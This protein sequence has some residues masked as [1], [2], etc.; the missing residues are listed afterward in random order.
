MTQTPPPNERL[1]QAILAVIEQQIRENNPP[2]TQQTLDRLMG[3]GLTKDKALTLIG[4]VVGL[5]VL[6]VMN[7]G[8]KFDEAAYIEKLLALPAMPWDAEK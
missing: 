7:R 3:Q 8:K 1:R 5:E 6:D 4:Y 2:E